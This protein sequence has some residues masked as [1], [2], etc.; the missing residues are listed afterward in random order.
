MRPLWPATARLA[1]AI[2]I[3]AAIAWTFAVAWRDTGTPPNAFNFFGYFTV[4]SNLLGM[5]VLAA[6]AVLTLARRRVPGWL[7]LARACATVYL[8]IVGVVYATLLAPLGEA[9]GVPSPWANTVLHVISPLLLPID[10]VLVR[11]RPPLPWRAL[12]WVLAYPAVWLG[13][14]LARGA[15][16]G[17]VPYPFLNPSNGYGS[18]AVVSFAIFATGLALGA[19]VWWVS[20]RLPGPQETAAGVV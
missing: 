20:H 13:V 12:P 2:L 6:V 8:V 10:W 4:Q 19:A 18:V 1:L 11:D 9:G 5:A 17:W 16:D 15:S 3:G 7:H 14:V